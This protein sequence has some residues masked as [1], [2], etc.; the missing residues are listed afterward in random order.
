VP[1][2]LPDR[3]LYWARC[4]LRRRDSRGA[5]VVPSIVFCCPC[6]SQSLRI[7][8]S[9]SILSVRCSVCD[10]EFRCYS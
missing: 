10:S 8:S 2:P 3:L 9:R 6:C 1:R 4:R 5:E 7:P